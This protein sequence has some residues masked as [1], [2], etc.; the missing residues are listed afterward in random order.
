M[1]QFSGQMGQTEMYFRQ[2]YA[3]WKCDINENTIGLFRQYFPKGFDFSSI[4]NDQIFLIR[5]A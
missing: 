1:Q 2:P 5:I 3:S 4:P